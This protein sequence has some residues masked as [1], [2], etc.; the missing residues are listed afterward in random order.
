M[1]EPTKRGRGRRN[2]IP[3][4]EIQAAWEGGETN[5]SELSR[6]FGVKRDSIINR[7]DKEKWATKGQIAETARAKVIDIV[8]K[9]AVESLEKAGTLDASTRAIEH[10]LEQTIPLYAK[11]AALLDASLDRAIEGR[12]RL[13]A[14][15]GETTALTDILSALSKFSRD[16]RTGAGLREGT[17]SIAGDDANDRPGKLY[18]VVVKTEVA[19][20]A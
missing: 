17:P 16:I 1:D 5:I 15:Q 10:L 7:R 18:E 9:R 13:G 19:E 8:T 3:W 20:S 2:D 6:R 14:T 12:V 11:A 4:P